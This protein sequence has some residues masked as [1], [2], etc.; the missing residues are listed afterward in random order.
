MHVTKASIHGNPNVGLYGFCTEKYV[1]VGP[2]VPKD[3]HKT[4]EEIFQKPVKVLTIAG[5][6]LLGVFLN[7]NKKCLLVPNI[8][9]DYELEAL[10]KLEIEY[11]V[12]ES[13]LTCLGNNIL[14][15]DKYALLSPEYKEEDE[16]SIGEAL[17]VPTK[18]RKLVDVNTVGSIAIMNDKGCLI[19]H[20]A[21]KQD[22]DLISTNFAIS[23]EHGS[24]N[25]GNPYVKSGILLNDHGFVM[26]DT[27]GGPEIVHADR[28]FGFLEQ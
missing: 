2:E 14:T 11:Q 27:S 1:L 18:R 26:G 3:M 15:N 25:M 16:K 10:D 12:I 23:V 17:G 20:E 4:Y 9:Y 8:A 21:S 6:S 5:T 7:G 19:H 13:R 24:V 22:I 28:V